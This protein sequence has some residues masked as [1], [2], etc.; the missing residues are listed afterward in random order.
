MYYSYVTF[1]ML[2]L[3][4]I[5]DTRV[6]VWIMEYWYI[7]LPA[8]FIVIMFIALVIGFFDKRVIRPLE[9]EEVTTINPVMQDLM[10]M[11]DDIR[12]VVKRIEN[13]NNS[14]HKD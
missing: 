7:T 12:K 1:F 4:T 2:I 6:G 13:E 9:M 3:L 14:S 10:F 11:V 8:V 5:K